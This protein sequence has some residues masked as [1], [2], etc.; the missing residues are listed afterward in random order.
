MVIRVATSLQ[1]MR[2]PLA[3]L[4]DPGGTAAKYCLMVKALS[5]TVT[6]C[7]VGVCLQ[8]RLVLACHVGRACPVAAASPQA[9]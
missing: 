8:M 1:R 7:A 6:R 2:R 9:A 4:R 3:V 5:F